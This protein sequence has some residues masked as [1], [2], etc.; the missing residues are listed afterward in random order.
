MLHVHLTSAYLLQLLS[1]SALTALLDCHS[2]WHPEQLSATPTIHSPTVKSVFY[3][4]PTPSLTLVSNN[5]HNI[6][7]STVSHQT[8]PAK[9][10]L[11]HL[12]GYRQ[13]HTNTQKANQH[14]LA[15]HQR[16][17]DAHFATQS[18]ISLL[19][20][21]PGELLLSSAC[22]KE[23]SPLLLSKAALTPTP[24]IPSKTPALRTASSHLALMPITT[25]VIAHTATPS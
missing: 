24:G 19:M 9:T 22:I 10:A 6:R 23:P 14:A 12:R 15:Q 5:A 7:L 8:N 18:H 13:P 17:A 20:H 11:H 16:H 1:C 3:C 21:L 4:P 2:M 25:A